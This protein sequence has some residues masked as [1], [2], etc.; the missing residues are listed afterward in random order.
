MAA[1]TVFA[2][3]NP[4][5]VVPAASAHSVTLPNGAVGATVS[6]TGGTVY[7]RA[8]GETHGVAFASTTNAIELLTGT[9]LE[10]D[11]PS[12]I[13]GNPAVFFLQGDAAA[14]V[15]ILPWFVG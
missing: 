1:A 11:A 15:R 7:Y 3:F 12:G 10:F 9:K 6:V 13:H 8:T 14:T 2:D 4:I 5:G